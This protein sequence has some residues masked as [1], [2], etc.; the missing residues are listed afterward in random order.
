MTTEKV[1]DDDS[2]FRSRVI[3]ILVVGV[4]IVVG[5]F[6]VCGG[7]IVLY[8]SKNKNHRTSEDPTTNTDSDAIQTK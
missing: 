5:C 8:K 4:I 2:S 7:I 3:Y 6:I 1:K